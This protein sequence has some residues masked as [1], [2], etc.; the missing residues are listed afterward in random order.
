MNRKIS[1]LD[2][3]AEDLKKKQEQKLQKTASAKKV[4]EKTA[5]EKVKLAK[6]V[7]IRKDLV[8]KAQNGNTVAYKGFGWKVVNASYKDKK[9]E[10]IVLQKIAE[11]SDKKVT[12]PAEKACVDPGNVYDYEV[13]DSYEVPEMQ[14]TATETEEKIAQE[15]AV[16]RTT[17]AGRATNPY[18]AEEL[19]VFNEIVEEAPVE[20][21]P[22]EEV[23]AEEEAPVEE[24]TEEAPVEE[25]PAE[26]APVEEEK[27][28]E[29][30]EAAAEEVTAEVEET[31]VE[32]V[33]AET[34]EVPAEHDMEAE[35]ECGDQCSEKV[36]EKEEKIAEKVE[37]VKEKTAEVEKKPMKRENPIIA[38]ILGKKKEKEEQIKKA[39]AVHTANSEKIAK[40]SARVA[41]KLDN[42]MEKILS[43]AEEL[44][45]AEFPAKYVS[46]S[47]TRLSNILC[48]E[49]IECTFDKKVSREAIRKTASSDITKAEC[50][51]A[52]RKIAEA[53][54]DETE[55]TIEQCKKAIDV[56]ASKEFE[57]G[58]K[59]AT[60]RIQRRVASR[61]G[62]EGL[63]F[64]F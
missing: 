17:P 6:R 7:I 47:L 18:K 50:D 28:E 54:V 43:D 20:E 26:E 61:L 13:R 15:N 53:V 55:D 8:P 36:A 62:A 24:V 63:Q 5:S 12:D 57:S 25:V 48:K 51:E 14:Q 2:K 23:P 35:K 40:I 56:I 52:I 33:T 59:V 29:V 44:V 46:A 3:V 42:Q 58:S 27:E 38:S 19:G 32:E 45:K 30:K 49:G 34:E 31:P 10:G 11:I 39:A 41:E 1:W 37:K 60:R 16:D 9:G 22:A 4:E 21:A 64:K